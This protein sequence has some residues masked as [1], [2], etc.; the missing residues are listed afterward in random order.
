MKQLV[1]NNVQK[2]SEFPAGAQDQPQRGN[3]NYRD[4]GR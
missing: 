3:R 1:V 4:D 2:T